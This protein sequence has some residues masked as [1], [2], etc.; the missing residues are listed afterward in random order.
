M[1][2]TATILLNSQDNN[3]ASVL[4]RHCL[5]TPLITGKC[6]K[7]ELLRNGNSWIPRTTVLLSMHPVE[8]IHCESCE[9][10]D[11]QPSRD[12]ETQIKLHI[13]ALGDHLAVNAASAVAATCA[14]L[15]KQ[16]IDAGYDAAQYEEPEQLL[17]LMKSVLISMEERQWLNEWMPPPGRMSVH[18]LVDNIVIVNDTYNANPASMLSA[19]RTLQSLG[20]STPLLPVR[21]LAVLGSMSELGVDEVMYHQKVMASASSLEAIDVMFWGCKWNGCP[22]TII[23]SDVEKAASRVFMPIAGN[24]E[25]ALFDAVVGWIKAGNSD[26]E[27]SVV[28][29]KGSRIARM[30]R[31]MNFVQSH[32][33]CPR[34]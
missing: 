16:R 3:A 32:T 9:R 23:G 6:W 13:P 28:L 26:K 7:T 33:S 25:Q 1:P 22:S 21:R 10:Q 29:L 19:L 14:C 24:Q 15:Q 12:A 2:P 11:W 31:V 17:Q 34:P 18:H 27:L 30:E 8:N 4:Q 5:E 20:V